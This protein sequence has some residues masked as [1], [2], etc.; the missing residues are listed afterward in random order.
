MR[1]V[2]RVVFVGLA[3]LLATPAGR[4][5]RG[6]PAGATARTVVAPR[7]LPR[8]P[9]PEEDPWVAGRVLVAPRG[10]V[11]P[12]TLA[13]RHGVRLAAPP[14]PS[15]WVAFAWDGPRARAD[16]LARLR[17]DRDVRATS[18]EGRTYGAAGSAIPFAEG[19]AAMGSV[20]RA[21]LH[22]LQWH[23]TAVDPM[24]V[25]QDLGR[26]TV[27]V[28]DTGVAYE[29]RA[30]GS[31]T[32][33]RAVSLRCVR[34]V[35]PADF[36]EHDGHPNDDH[37]HGTHIA[38]LVAGC[39]ALPGVAPGVRVMPVKVL[40]HDDVGTELALVDGIHHAVEN[41]AHVVNM[42]LSF[43]PA[44]VAGPALVEALERAAHAD[45]VLVAAAGNEGGEVVTQP[46]ASPLV[47]AVGALRPIDAQRLAPAGYSNASPRVDL[48]SPGG[49]L[50][51]D[52]NGD[53]IVDGILAETIALQQPSSLGWWLYAGT[54]QAAALVSAAAAHLV[55]AGL[56]AQRVRAVLEGTTRPEPLAGQPW[57]DGHGSGRLSV[58]AARDASRND[59][60]APQSYYVSLLPWLEAGTLQRVRPRLQAVVL[61]SRAR[62]ASGVTLVGSLEGT[63]GTAWV[64][65]TDDAGTCRV[66]GHWRTPRPEDRWTWRAEGV[67]VDG[68]SW[69]PGAAAFTNRGLQAILGAID[70]DPALQGAV[71][72]FRWRAGRVPQLGAV[73]DGVAL[74]DLDTLR[75]QT[76]RARLLVAATLDATPATAAGSMAISAATPGL[77]PAVRMVRD[78]VGGTWAWR[79]LRTREGA[80]PLLVMDALALASS[81]LDLTAPGLFG[82]LGR[83]LTPMLVGTGPMPGPVAQNRHNGLD[84]ARTPVG[85]WLEAGG[86]PAWQQP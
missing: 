38:S 36:I 20:P 1:V 42:S 57:V 79:L 41:G 40:D 13:R 32:W 3:L 37:Q 80:H 8:P 62:R 69:R 52:R 76:P 22:A 64:C 63:G 14:G 2:P 67:V 54:S 31:R 7:S 33:R 59:V 53:G 19:P 21:R 68:V 9:G 15:G 4:G 17:A 66:D 48:A 25:P 24:P 71:L 82:G 78:D 39:G 86:W 5:A 34:F 16:V 55:H 30:D 29:D 12:T 74:V 60:P 45:V 43:G 56:D 81:P 11:D 23:R 75:G 47:V 58:P 70:R 85:S 77:A 72:G 61:D 49:A 83:G 6:A 27:A 65:R 46:A 28:L 73:A 18:L 51:S 50:D 26:V 44:Y 35:A 84:L 10:G